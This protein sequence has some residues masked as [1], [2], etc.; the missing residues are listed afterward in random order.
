MAG[1]HLAG[2]ISHH[3]RMC[4]VN[5]LKTSTRSLVLIVIGLPITWAAMAPSDY[6]AGSLAKLEV[7]PIY[8]ADPHGN[9]HCPFCSHAIPRA[10]M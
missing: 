7:Q 3:P 9:Q 4:A 10:G 1:V 6:R 5:R 8:A 2:N